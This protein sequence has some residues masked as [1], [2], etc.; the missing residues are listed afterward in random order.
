MRGLI[1]LVNDDHVEN[2]LEGNFCVCICRIACKHDLKWLV[3]FFPNQLQIQ[4]IYFVYVKRDT[5]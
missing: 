2:N 1:S 3:H 4:N 5:T